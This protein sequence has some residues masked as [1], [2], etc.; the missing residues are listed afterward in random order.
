MALS[1]GVPRL[2]HAAVG[3]GRVLAL[4]SPSSAVE[5]LCLPRMDSATVFARLLDEHNGGTL[6]L[7]GMNGPLQGIQR[8]LPNTNVA[9]TELEVAGGSVHVHDFCPRLQAGL[10]EVYAP[11]EFVRLVTPAGGEP[12]VIVDFDPRPDYAT[13]APR[14]LPDVL[15]VRVEGGERSI[16]LLTNA[17]VDRILERAPINITGPTFFVV[18]SADDPPYRD[19]ANVRE[20]LDLTIRGWRS[21]A[22]A[23]ALPTFAADAVLRSALCLKLHVAENTGAVLAAATTSI[24]E[25]MGTARTWDY[26]YCWVRDAAFVVDAL[27]RLSQ[28]RESERFIGYLERILTMGPLQPVYGMGGE[29]DIPEIS[30]DHLAGFGGNGHVRIGNAAAI[31]RQND[32]MGELVLSLGAALVDPRLSVRDLSETFN[33]IAALVEDSIVAAGEPDMGIWEY[34]TQLRHHTFSRAMCWAA[35]HHGSTLARRFGRHTLAERWSQAAEQERNVI[36]QRGYSER[37]GCFTQ[38][39]DGQYPDASNLLLP[40]LGLLP[41]TDPRMISTVAVYERRL[42][43]NGLMLRYAHA[44]DLG[45]PRSAF[46]ICSFWWAELLA[47]QGRLRDAETVFNR[48]MSFANPLGLFSED[49]DPDTGVALGNYPQAYTHVGLIHAATTIGQLR[50]ARDGRARGWE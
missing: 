22:R 16:R 4:I 5:W 33:L 6:R 3:N 40:V 20:H 45:I 10:D 29:R 44:D 31:Q 43:R 12:S 35:M 25:E 46:S 13:I 8:Y 38:A 15:G 2:D 28:L 36:L 24:P 14:L 21:W 39:L 1:N 27:R 41:A 49:L 42:V 48:V 26:R 23:C 50:E 34:R 47:L 7:C 17:P 18:T 9:L 32:L 37:H 11:A 30:L 19:A